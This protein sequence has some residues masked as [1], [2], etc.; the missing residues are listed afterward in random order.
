MTLSD[1]SVM[2]AYR[3]NVFSQNGEDGIVSELLRRLGSN[4]NKWFV[5]VGAWD[6]KVLSNT[7]N[8]VKDGWKG[9]NV[10]CDYNKF[11]ELLK[12]CAQ[13]PGQMIPIQAF[14]DAGNSKLD[15]LLPAEV[16]LDFDLLSIDIDADDYHAWECMTK[17]T[18]KI[19]IIE[20][21]SNYAPGQ[22]LIHD[23]IRD[24]KGGSPTSGTS[25]TSML[26]LA[27]RKG[28]SLV[29]HTG[30]MVFLRTELM[31]TVQLKTPDDV[32]SLFLPVGQYEFVNP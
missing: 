6:G 16:P 3:R 32:G 8:L 19:V 11:R 18:P 10:E 29:V 21:N 14:V 23:P 12:T 22:H 1:S 5:E 17:F 26:E 9:V 13:H 4:V 20:I 28:Y 30:N 31:E 27:G 2:L 25:F 7:Y 24:P 15:D